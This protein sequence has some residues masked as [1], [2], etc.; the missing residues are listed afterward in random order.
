MLLFITG[1]APSSPS[2]GQEQ[3]LI[4]PNPPAPPPPGWGVPPTEA[5]WETLT[6]TRCGLGGGETLGARGRADGRM[7]EGGGEPL[8]QGG[9]GPMGGRE[10]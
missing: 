6:R 5:S 10:V 2:P 9:G 4:T 7:E 8:G 1:Q 3:L